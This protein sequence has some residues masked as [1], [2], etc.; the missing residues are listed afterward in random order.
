[1]SQLSKV[2]YRRHQWK[3]KAKQRADRERYQRQQT[4]RIS[5]ERDRTTQALQAAQARLQ[6]LEAHL[7][8]L[9]APLQRQVSRPK[10]EVVLGSLHLFVVARIGLRAVSR[11]LSLLAWALGIKKAPCPHTVINWVTRL[12]MVRTQSARR[13]EGLP[14]RQAP[15]SNGLIWL[16]DSSIGLGT[17]KIVAVLAVDAPHHHLV[18]SALSLDRVHCLGVSVADAWTG[19]TIADLLD[20]LIAQMGRPAASLKDGG[21]ALH[22]AVATLD[23]QG[24]GSP[25]IDDISHAVAGMLKRTYQAHPA[26]ATFLTACGQVSGTLTHTILA[27]LAPPTVRTKARC[28]PVHRLCTWADQVLTLSPAGGAKQGSA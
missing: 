11:V 4:A 9:E 27:C 2:T 13:L 10:V 3:H 15:L 17:G 25:C 18:P 24:L 7:R 22:K 1:M 12:A 6:Q 5:A 16:I 23:A 19:D 14:L 28:M 8:Q 26:L 21:S 20:R